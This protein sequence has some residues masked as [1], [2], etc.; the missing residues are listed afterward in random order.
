MKTGFYV[1]NSISESFVSNQKTK[2]GTYQWDQASQEVG[3]GKQAA[4]QT[5]NKQFS[6]TIN[7]AYSNYLAA[8]RGIRGSV[9]GEGYKEAYVQANQEQ[10]HAQVIESNMTAAMARQEIGQD[11]NMMRESI[12][13]AY[14]TE[15]ANMDRAYKFADDY[16]GYLKTLSG[17][18]DADL[19]YLDESQSAASIDDMY[20]T[21][22]Q[23]QPRDYVDEKG[24]VA[25]S[26]TEWVNSQLK[27]NDS[28]LTWAKWL[29]S[30]GGLSQVQKAAGVGKNVKPV[31]KPI[32]EEPT[33]EPTVKKHST[34]ADRKGPKNVEPI[35]RDDAKR[36]TNVRADRKG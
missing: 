5:V 2:G 30:Q 9:M 4:L 28:D 17:L 3:L 27:G 36:T 25:L 7:N 31:E 1:P 35:S 32:V 6:T 23:A 18:N 16:F 13:K 11:S 8:N 20:D 33:V 34:R 15:V 29:F 21:V 24:N 14:D 10:L 12:Q 26:Y 19:K 22:F